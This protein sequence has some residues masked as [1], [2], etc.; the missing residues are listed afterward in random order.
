M[1]YKTGHLFTIKL[2]EKLEKYI[3]NYYIEFLLII[4]YFIIWYYAL[5]S[6]CLPS[7]IINIKPTNEFTSS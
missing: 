2:V 3:Y 5:D 7:Q 4:I 6:S 1:E